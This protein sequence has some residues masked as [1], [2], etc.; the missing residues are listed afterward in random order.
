VT[1]FSAVLHDEAVTVAQ[2]RVPDGTN[3]ITQAE[4]I[5]E[6][7]EIPDGKSALFTMDAAHAQK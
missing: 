1:L 3:E 5:L 6:A 7:A 2:V 4:A